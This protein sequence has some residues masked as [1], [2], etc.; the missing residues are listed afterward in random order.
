M[1]LK[2]PTFVSKSIN[3][4][5]RIHKPCF[6]LLLCFL[7]GVSISGQNYP[8]GSGNDPDSLLYPGGAFYKID[9]KKAVKKATV[10]KNVIFMIGDGMG[11]AHITAAQTANGGKL[12][13][14]Q[15]PVVGLNTTQS[16]SNFV[17]DS[18]AGGTA[19]ATGKKTYNGAIG[20]DDDTLRIENIR[21]VLSEK[22]KRTGVVAT[23]DVTHATPAAFVAHQ[24]S[25]EMHEEIAMDFVYSGIDLF[26]G[27]GLQYF[28]ARKD[29]AN[30]LHA[31]VSSGYQLDTQTIASKPFL[32]LQKFSPQKRFAGLYASGHME[33]A[34]GGRGSYLPEATREAISF[35]DNNP[36]GF[37]L[38]IEGSQIDWGGHANHTTY[39]ITETLDF[40][41]AVG[42]ALRFAAEDGQTLVVVTADHETAGMAVYSGDYKTGMVRAAYS[43]GDHSGSMVPVFA[44]GPGSELF[45]G[46]YDNTDIPKK[47]LQ[48]MKISFPKP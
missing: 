22:G 30:L 5:N 12:Y 31:L 13:M 48:A 9:I 4:K 15:F 44:F 41:Q 25:R 24:P 1:F 34:E 18:G 39:I 35:L 37:F 46:M 7:T 20:V 29:S 19:L 10:P 2:I 8:T 33:T 26:M 14:D 42:E 28:N 6:F 16:A 11:L 32:N 40:D 38:M 36:K 3:M 27:G 17:T 23:C 21:E 47:I 45:S 43:S